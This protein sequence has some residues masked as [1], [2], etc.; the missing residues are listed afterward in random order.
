MTF[1]CRQ[2]FAKQFDATPDDL[3]MVR[4]RG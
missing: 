1:L 2:A 3:D 4:V